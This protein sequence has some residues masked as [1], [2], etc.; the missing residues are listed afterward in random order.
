MTEQDTAQES[1]V[2]DEV[3]ENYD[4]NN[5][6]YD[7]QTNEN[8]QYDNDNGEKEFEENLDN[9]LEEKGISKSDEN[10]LEKN[11]IKEKGELE[12]RISR[13]EEVESED[14]VVEADKN[15]NKGKETQK[16]EYDREHLSEERIGYFSEEEKEKKYEEIKEKA[17][18]NTEYACITK[19]HIGERTGILT[20]NLSTMIQNAFDVTAGKY[21]V[22][23]SNKETLE[24][25]VKG[26]EVIIFLHGMWQNG[27][28]WRKAIKQA[29]EKG[30]KAIAPSYDYNLPYE[31]VMNDV[32]LPL[33][34]ELKE[35][36][37]RIKVVGHSTGADNAKYAA[38]YDKSFREDVD[39]I[40][41]SAPVTNYFENKTFQ[42]KLISTFIGM[43]KFDAEDAILLSPDPMM[44][45]EVIIGTGDRLVLPEYS[46]PIYNGK[47][48]IVPNATHF[49]GAGGTKYMNEIYINSALNN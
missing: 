20:K 44:N 37:A 5:Q 24:N 15:L 17:K 21:I 33:I 10:K 48:R 14:V 47:T 6:E 18:R 3:Q 34:A 7:G 42:H 30:V 4:S 28:A 49:N 2:V 11:N 26:D 9:V 39:K 29:E 19:P 22:D 43:P 45:H 13:I 32:I 46:M 1:E 27:G 12:K 35:K 41:L 8:T 36:G 31:K 23:K 40:V 38:L 25:I 16:K